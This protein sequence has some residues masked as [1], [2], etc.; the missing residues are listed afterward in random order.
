MRE[1][2]PH[3]PKRRAKQL[4][5]LGLLLA[6]PATGLDCRSGEG[7]VIVEETNGSFVCRP[8]ATGPFPGVL[9]NHGGLGLAVGGDLEG[10]C[11]ALAGAGYLAS[12]PLRED[13]PGKNIL[14]H[15]QEV[16]DALDALHGMLEVDPARIGVMGFSRGGMLSLGAALQ[17]A[18]VVGATVLMA[19]APGNG[20]LLQ[21]LQ[22]VSAISAP[23]LIQVAANDDVAA[24]HVF[25]AQQVAD[26]LQ[27]E[28][29]T[30]THSVLDPYPFP[31]C[32]GCN[33]HDVFQGVDDEFTD[34]WCEVRTFLAPLLDGV[35][36]VPG[37]SGQTQLWA[38]VLLTAAGVLALRGRAARK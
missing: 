4:T 5:A 1:A 8:D 18:G 19:P 31:G 9:Y 32:T 37:M 16:L 15:Q 21:L 2:G 3:T 38:A 36:R 6:A 33:G 23:M 22:D 26:A 24:D 20:Y 35:A 14:A 13:P 30:Y 7:A 17:R 10:T 12:V 11:R 27:A 34:Y 29:K 25:Y 28:S